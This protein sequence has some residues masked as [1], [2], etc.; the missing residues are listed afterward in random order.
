MWLNHYIGYHCNHICRSANLEEEEK[1]QRLLMQEEHRRVVKAERELY[2]SMVAQAQQVWQSDNIQDL[3]PSAPCSRTAIQHYSFDF[4]QQVH[5]PTLF[6][7]GQSTSLCLV[8]L[9][10]LVCVVR[11]F[12]DK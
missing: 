6:S 2:N 12:L 7:Q 9:A 4:A 11:G 1:S 10:C 3:Q 8:R 5:L